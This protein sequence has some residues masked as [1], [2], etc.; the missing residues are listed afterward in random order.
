MHIQNLN[1]YQQT[2]QMSYKGGASYIN[3]VNPASYYF[4]KF[5]NKS[6]IETLTKFD[7]ILPNDHIDFFVRFSQPA[8]FNNSFVIWTSV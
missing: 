3:K 1:T 7:D 6:A 8:C 4:D 5:F 2:S